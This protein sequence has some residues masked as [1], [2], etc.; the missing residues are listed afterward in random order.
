MKNILPLAFGPDMTWKGAVSFKNVLFGMKSS[1]DAASM[2]GW[3]PPLM[4]MAPPF[5][6]VGLV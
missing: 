6:S 5:V 3:R 2:T 1:S 4:A